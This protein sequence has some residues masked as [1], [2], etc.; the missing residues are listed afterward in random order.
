MSVKIR[1][2]K[3]SRL[4]PVT[5]GAV[6][7]I[8]GSGDTKMFLQECTNVFSKGGGEKLAEHFNVPFLGEFK[9]GLVFL[10]EFKTLLLFLGELE[11]LL[12]LLSELETL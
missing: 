6:K 1:I 5:F 11:T 8:I 9:T 12:F 2:S 3:S 7:M 4:F 10:G